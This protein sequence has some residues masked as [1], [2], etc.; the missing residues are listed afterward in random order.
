MVVR[1]VGGDVVIEEKRR[2]AEE[3]SDTGHC[4]LVDWMGYECARSGA[5]D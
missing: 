1:G 4:H 5:D 2:E 3:E